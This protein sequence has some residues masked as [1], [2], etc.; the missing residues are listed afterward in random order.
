[1]P[2]FLEFCKFRLIFLVYGSSES[3]IK[4][5]RSRRDGLLKNDANKVLPR[6]CNDPN[7]DCYLTGNSYRHFV[8]YYCFMFPCR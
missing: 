7:E 1:M 6:T 8:N 3:V 5:L 4:A 2:Q